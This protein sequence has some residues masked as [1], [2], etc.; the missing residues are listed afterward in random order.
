ML[1]N[2]FT[3][4]LFLPLVVLSYWL[5]PQRYRTTLLLLASYVFYMNWKPAYGLLILGL[6]VVNYFIGLAIDR[7]TPLGKP[8]LVAGAI[9]NIGC[10]C[11]FKYAAFLI[12]SAIDSLKWLH[13]WTGSS[14]IPVPTSPALNIIL[15]LGISFFTFVFIHYI[16]DV[17]RGSKPVKNFRDFAA[18]RMT[19]ASLRLICSALVK[20]T[21]NL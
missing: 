1:F 17:F 13:N 16:T 10:L 19:L 21:L 14:L 18:V 3:Y 20:T 5:T 11:F 7:F 15:P 12:E 2:S 8:L 4:L 9:F 6:T